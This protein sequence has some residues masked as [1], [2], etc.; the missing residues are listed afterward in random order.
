M[1]IIVKELKNSDSEQIAPAIGVGLRHPHYQDALDNKPKEVSFLEIHAENF[2]SAGG[3]THALLDDVCKQYSLSVHGTSLGLGS[4]A[5]VPEDVLNQFAKLVAQT[6]PI[7]VSEH[8]CFNRAMVNGTLLHSGDLLPI[9]YNQDSLDVISAQIYRVQDRIKRPILIENLSAYINP[10]DLD[11]HAQDKM[12]EIEFLNQMCKATGCGLLLDLNNLLVNAHN[13]NVD[14][15]VNTILESLEQLED[16]N[17]GEIHLAGFNKTKV[18]GYYVDDHGAEVSEECWQLYSRLQHRYNHVPT[19]IEWDTQI[20]PWEVLI[21]QAKQ[22]H[23][24]AQKVTE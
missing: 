21:R 17:V 11:N 7:L 12:S 19:L 8:L 13:R 2:F 3:I 1:G 9:P 14:D 6:Q 24:I 16:N 20:P 15:P 22:A 23:S 4:N 10:N 5:P 18:H